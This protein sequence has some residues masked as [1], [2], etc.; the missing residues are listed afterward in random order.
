MQAYPMMSPKLATQA[1][2]LPIRD[3]PVRFAIG[4]PD[5]FTSNSWKIWAAKSGVYIVCRDNFKETKVSLHTSADPRIPG[6][7]RMGFTTESLPK[8]GHLLPQD[9]NRAWEVWDEP[10]TSLPGTIVAFRLIFATSELA[11]NREQR[12]PKEWKEVIFIESAPPGKLT[13]LTL[14]V[15]SGEPELCHESEPSFRLASFDIGNGRRAQL[16][17]HGDPENGFDDRIRRAVAEATA[18]AQS[19]GI[20]I[21]EQAYGYFFGFRPDGCRFI[22]GARFHRASI[23]TEQPSA[24]HNSP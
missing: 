12:K 11:V 18:Q 24:A 8:I 15:T 4:A 22:Y 1:G 17:A 5:G 6:R 16:I 2:L 9:E 3:K 21:P 10:P 13:V 7:W 20:A 23:A 14:F 19:K